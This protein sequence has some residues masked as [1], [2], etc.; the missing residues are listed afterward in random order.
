MKELTTRDGPFVKR[1]YFTHVEIETICIDEL[2]ALGYY[3]SG[4]EPV[5]IDRFL[6]KRFGVVPRSDDLPPGVLGYTRFGRSGVVE[7]VIS[8]ELEEARGRVAERRARTTFAHEGGHG[9]L[10]GH[11]FATENAQ[12]A[13]PGLDFQDS[14]ILCRPDALSAGTPNRYDGRWWEYQANTAMACLLLPRDHVQKA[15]EPYLVHNGSFGI[16]V[17]DSRREEEA[18]AELSE[19]FDVNPVVCRLRLKAIYETTAG[20]QL[21][22]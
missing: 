6:E 4:P 11:L 7:I 18:I 8:R 16:R 1:P 14:R 9:L 22:L 15:L 2:R 12:E 13:F 21:K 17:L 5:R 20:A 10:H 3:P 19:I